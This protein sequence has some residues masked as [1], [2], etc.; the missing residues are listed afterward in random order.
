[1]FLI[2]TRKQI[3]QKIKIGRVLRA[4][5]VDYATMNSYQKYMG[6]YSSYT[7]A[8]S[9][10]KNNLKIIIS[11][12]PYDILTMSTDKRYTSCQTIPHHNPDTELYFS[13][14]LKY[15]PRSIVNGI[16]IAYLMPIDSN[17]IKESYSRMMIIPYIPDASNVSED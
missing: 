7:L 4:L 17:N 3:P 8:Y 11:R 16:I 10:P 1:M 13:E 15:I 12:H 6:Q 14:L 5:N 2:D 9:D